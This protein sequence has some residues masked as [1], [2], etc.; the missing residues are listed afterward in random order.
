VP[1]LAA[2]GTY[3]GNINPAKID[4]RGERPERYQTRFE[5]IDRLKPFALA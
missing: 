2:A 1:Y 3:L 5:I 4:Q